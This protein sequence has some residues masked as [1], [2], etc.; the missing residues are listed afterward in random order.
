MLSPYLVSSA[1]PYPNKTLPDLLQMRAG[2]HPDR[3]VF[4]FLQD[5]DSD[6]VT[7][8]YGELDRRARAIGAWLES[9]N[10]SEERALILY[11]PGLE[12]I[13][14]FLGCLYAGVTAVPAYPPRLNR[15][16]PASNRWR[17]IRRRNLH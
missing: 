14:S 16:S 10:A 5:G 1:S 8:T 15:P 6:V 9:L 2:E 17:Q 3:L 13:A 4:R 12:Y 11:P 7:I